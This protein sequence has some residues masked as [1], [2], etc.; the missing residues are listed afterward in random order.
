MRGELAKAY[1][2]CEDSPQP[3]LPDLAAY[4]AK[5]GVNL[6][7]IQWIAAD[8]P[9][10]V[11]TAR[12]ALALAHEPNLP[13]AKAWANYFIGVVFYHWNELDRSVECLEPLVRQPY[14]VNGTVFANAT[15]ALALAYQAQ[16]RSAEAHAITAAAIDHLRAADNLCLNLLEIF[17]VELALRQGNLAAAT[18]WAALHAAF[19]PLAPVVD[20]V[21]PQL[22]RPKILLAHTSVA[23]RQEAVQLLLAARDFFAAIHNTRFLVE[24]LALLALAWWGE[25]DTE[26]LGV[27]ADALRLA[28]PGGLVRVFVD[29][30]PRLL[31]P[32]ELS[33]VRNVTPAF[34][35]QIVAALLREHPAAAAPSS[36]VSPAL[37]RPA[38]ADQSGLIEALTPREQEILALL[39]QRL[40][41]KEIAQTLSIAADTVKEHI[42][43]L[44]G[45]LAVGDRRAA[46][47][48]AAALGLLP[49][50]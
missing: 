18:Q 25:R 2:I 1:S 4:Q 49:P 28:S 7:F 32:L 9:A 6:C 36:A 40:T 21:A 29:I 33:A 16:G 42:R 11:R 5:M 43:H 27:L 35:T 41:N 13:E 17:Q 26:A 15:C 19:G 14:G 12:R 46:V 47:A 34:T 24:T 30:G 50:L 38:P 44:F 23:A 48:K 10:L 37:R 20:F 39:A 8:L 45:K 22:V 31:R 3:P